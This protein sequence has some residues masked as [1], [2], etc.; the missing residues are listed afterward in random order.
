MMLGLSVATGCNTSNIGDEG[1]PSAS[2]IV[3]VGSYR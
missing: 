3:G 1:T 2:S